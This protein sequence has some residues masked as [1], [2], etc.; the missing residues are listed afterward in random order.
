MD[1]GTQ[2]ASK[3]AAQSA[4]RKTYKE[5]LKAYGIKKEEDI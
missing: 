3:E 4:L 2:K 1:A 5:L